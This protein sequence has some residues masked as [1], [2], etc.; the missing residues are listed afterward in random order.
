[1]S[2]EENKKLVLRWKDE[3]RNKRNVNIIAVLVSWVALQ[4][5]GLP[6]PVSYL[7][8]VWGMPAIVAVFVNALAPL[9][10]LSVSCGSSGWE[11]W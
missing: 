6:K 3:I 10:L 11:L 2:T 7:G 5:R 9:G 4:K 1:M 8:L